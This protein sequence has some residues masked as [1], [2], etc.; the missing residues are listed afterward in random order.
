MLWNEIGPLLVKLSH[1]I[2]QSHMTFFDALGG[3]YSQNEFLSSIIR[4]NTSSHKS[5]N[6]L[7]WAQKLFCE[8]RDFYSKFGISIT[9][10]SCDTSKCALKQVDG[11]PAI[12]AFRQIGDRRIHFKAKATLILCVFSSSD[13]GSKWWL[14]YSLLHPTTK[15][16]NRR[17]SCLPL[18][19]SRHNGG[20]MTA[21]WGRV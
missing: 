4:I 21:H 10:L 12:D 1:L 7:K 16:L 8:L 13:V 19:R 18:H 15:H 5:Q 11:N 2:A 17:H 3:I 14:L 20:H 6:Q 9:R